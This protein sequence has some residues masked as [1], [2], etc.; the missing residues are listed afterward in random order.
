MGSGSSTGERPSVVSSSAVLAVGTASSR[1][2]GLVRVVVSAA[3]LGPTLVGDLFV[4]VNALPATLFMIVAGSAISS[5]LVPPL[6]RAEDRGEHERADRLRANA[7]GL[8][9]AGL[10]IVGVGAVLFVPVL[11]D[12]FTSG[13][14]SEVGPEARRIAAILLLG[15]IPQTVVYGAISVL[16]AIQHSRSKFLLPSM[17]SI[18][19]NLGV[20]GTVVVVGLN[21]DVTSP[22]TATLLWLVGGSWIAVLAHLLI[23]YIGA[24]RAVGRIRLGFE[25]RDDD[26]RSL[27]APIRE[28]LGWSTV[29]SAQSLLLVVAAT[30]AGVGGVQSFEIAYL[31]YHLPTALAGRPVAAAALPALARQPSRSPGQ[32]RRYQAALALA[33]WVAIPAGAAMVSLHS[34]LAAL[35]AVGRFDDPGAVEMLGLAILGLG[36]GAACNALFEVVRQSSM[37]AE[38][39]AGIRRSSVV[40]AV[41]TA[42]GLP[43]VV[44]SMEGPMLLLGLGLVVSVGDLVATGVA[45]SS[46]VD[47]SATTLLRRSA[48]AVVVAAGAAGALVVGVRGASNIGGAAA[49]T[50]AL[51]GLFVVIFL[52][53]SW[54]TSRFGRDWRDIVAELGEGADA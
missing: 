7:L 28:S 15:I 49:S 33:G 11:A 46:L 40:R 26:V 54:V 30:F 18:L 12:L 51:A 31:G 5:I 6:V 8:C 44:A 10:A 21:S 13:Y 52:S 20:I 29:V 43:I 41:C 24:R 17:A 42:V 45:H 27:V 4:A 37:A 39:L 38:H 36:V 1:L 35:I 3:V 14:D 9:V 48:A 16:V 23:Q 50:P 34:E 19:E 25:V 32:V 22:S 53:T 2:S 47:S